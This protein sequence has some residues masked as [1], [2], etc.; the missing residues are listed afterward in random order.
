MTIY[1]LV[2]QLGPVTLTGY[3]VMMMVSFV[4]AGWA[5]QLELRERGLNEDYA[6]DIILA[7]VIGGLVGAKVWYV[8]VTRDWSA[9]FRRG[10]FVWYGGFLGGV[11]AVL[12]NGW[13]LRVP[14]R[15]TMEFTAAAL[16]VGY[17]LG[18]VGCFLVN[19]DYGIPTSLPWGMRFPRGLPPTTVA[20][21]EHMH[22]TFPPTA[23][24][25]EVVA[26]HPTELYETTLMLLAF[27]WLWRARTHH[28]ALGWRFGVYLVL[29]GTERFLIEFIR[30]K[31]DRFF[32]PLSLA[33]IASLGVVAVGVVVTARLWAPDRVAPGV[34]GHLAPRAAA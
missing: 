24:P 19:D 21:L 26:V 33:Q 22:V 25:L 20:N 15:Y 32:G 23:N 11:V 14:P 27:A 1:P 6:A 18:R 13:R 7:A 4:M 34:S 12:A 31:D 5:I 8:V 16:A 9:L 30:A 3:G 17:A 28:H 29:A 2:L 10:G